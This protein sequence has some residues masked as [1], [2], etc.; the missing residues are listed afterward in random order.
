MKVF[1][2]V[3]VE[4]YTGDY[5]REVYGNG[6]GLEYLLEKCSDHGCR[7]TF[8]VEALGATR[9]G[10]DPVRKICSAI[11]AAGQEVQLHVHP[12]V[13]DL[14][15]IEDE[16]DVLWKHGEREQGR[17]IGA[18]LESL[19][20]CGVND[21]CAFR[22]GDFAADTRTLAA[23][24]ECGLT[25]GSNRDLDMKSSIRSKINGMFPVQNDISEHAGVVDLPVSVL[26]SAF[27]FLDGRY[28][29]MEISAMGARE[30]CDGLS[31][32][33]KAGYR[34]A[35]VLT[36]ADEVFRHNGSTA[37][38]VRKNRRRLE[39][40]LEFVTRTD[41]MRMATV[42][43]CREE[44]RAP[45]AQRAILRANPLYSFVR[46]MQQARERLRRL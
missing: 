30:M 13:A 43:E 32:M 2:T 25:L 40:L 37:V 41:G 3:D 33:A 31:R 42:S 7:A 10:N 44:A 4:C 6:L 1:L 21:V 18:G 19:A 36:H 14:D 9:W 46:I 35:T 26:R 34:C 23:M 8:F 16:D 11:A 17:L 38:P 39:G 22:A 15:G 5:E 12:V 28:R 20:A 27:P 24:R 29:H 45:A